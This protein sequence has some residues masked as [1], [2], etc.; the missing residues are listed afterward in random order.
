MNH[1]A[2]ALLVISVLA[3]AGGRVAPVLAQQPASAEHPVAAAQPD[4]NAPPPPPAYTAPPKG[5][6]PAQDT[7]EQ[8]EALARWKAKAEQ[9]SDDA[10]RAHNAMVT[11][12]YNSHYGKK[13]P[14]TP[15][16]IQ[17]QGEGFIQPGAFPTADYCGTCHQEAYSQW[18]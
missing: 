8:R 16:N 13:S 9:K 14:Y 7:P 12:A 2:R 6:P 10:R 3:L 4:P 18:R 17:V 11:P 15:G 1:Y 5:A